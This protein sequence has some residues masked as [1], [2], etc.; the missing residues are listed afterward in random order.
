MDLITAEIIREY[1][2]TVSEEMSETVT[3]TAMSPVF[4]EGHDYSTAVFYFDGKNISLSLARRSC[5]NISMPR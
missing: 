2:L 1:L 4:N 3:R 5:R